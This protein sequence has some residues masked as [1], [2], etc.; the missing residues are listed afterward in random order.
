MPDAIEYRAVLARECGTLDNIALNRGVGIRLCGVQ[1]RECQPCLPQSG[2]VAHA[3]TGALMTRALFGSQKFLRTLCSAIMPV[4][5]LF[6]AAVTTVSAQR[7]GP[8]E[9][10]ITRDTVLAFV[11]NKDAAT[12]SVFDRLNRNVVATTRVCADATAI[13]LTSDDVSLIVRCRRGTP[14]YLNTASYTLGPRP[15]TAQ[16]RRAAGLVKRLNEVIVVGTIHSEHRTSTRYSTAVLRQ[17]LTA[18]RPDFVLTEIP[19]NRFDAAM[20]EF[21]TTGQIV[22]PRVVRF[23]EYVDVL[24]PLSRELRFTIVPTAG[25]TRPMD[26]FRSATLK[27]IAADSRRTDDW[28]EYQ[29]ATRLADSLVQSRGAD[30]PYFIN[31]DAYDQIQTAAHE[32]YNRLFNTELGPGGWDNINVAHFGN[33]ARALDAHTGEGKRF[34]ITYGAGHK[35]WFMRALRQRRDITVLEV[36]PFLERIGVP[37]LD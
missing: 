1:S 13:S 36:A 14:Q 15:A 24:F 9:R 26:Q 35:E 23:P 32:P 30:D 8:P 5:A 6:M 18:M 16:T 10:A 25:W 7:L 3:L 27:R 37:R 21:T 19:P 31:S 28:R 2:C 20:R 22:E 33:I 34:V 29:K 4:A 11:L 12:V 17:L